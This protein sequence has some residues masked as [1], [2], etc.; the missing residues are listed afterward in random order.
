MAEKPDVKDVAEKIRQLKEWLAVFQEEYDIPAD[1]MET[2]NKK[3]NEL[4][5][6]V[7]DITCE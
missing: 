3:I 7:A 4:V 1:A 6:E 2:L 5:D